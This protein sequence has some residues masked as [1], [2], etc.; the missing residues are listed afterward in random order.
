MFQIIWG[1][2]GQTTLHIIGSGLWRWDHFDSAAYKVMRV[3]SALRV[4]VVVVLDLSEMSEVPDAA[5]QQI[6]HVLDHSPRNLARA[7]IVCETEFVKWHF[8]MQ[9]DRR[10]AVVDRAPDAFM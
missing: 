4:P 10:F 3:L 5:A 8:T 7:I 1:Q 6:Q 9:N 2:R